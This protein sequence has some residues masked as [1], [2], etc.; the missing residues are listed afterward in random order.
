MSKRRVTPP[1]TGPAAETRAGSPAT[2]RPGDVERR[3]RRAVRDDARW[4]AVPALALA[5]AL[6]LTMLVP[7][8][9]MVST[10]LMDEIEVFSHPPPLLPASPRW[11]NY[12][13]ALTALPFDRASSCHW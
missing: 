5:I 8:L 6:A 10:S 7:F 11:A 13:D 2:G 12:V 4:L 9:Y 3:P 1:G